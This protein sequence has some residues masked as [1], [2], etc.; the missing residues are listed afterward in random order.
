[1]AILVVTN[2]PKTHWS[3]QRF[4]WLELVHELPFDL[5][6]LFNIYDQTPRMYSIRG[7]ILYD[8]V[9]AVIIKVKIDAL[10]DIIY[11]CNNTVVTGLS[12]L[13]ELNCRT[14]SQSVTVVVYDYYRYNLI[15]KFTLVNI[16]FRLKVF[17]WKNLWKSLVTEVDRLITMKITPIQLTFHFY[18]HNSIY[19]RL[20]SD[21]WHAIP[22]HYDWR[23]EIWILDNSSLVWSC[24]LL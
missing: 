7:I 8:G 23:R 17:S 5:C 18:R 13:W 3:W 11:L 22:G 4:W 2:T 6:R 1:M 12:Y 10:F 15:I 19:N 24:P 16:H 20:Y 21:H 9:L 14:V